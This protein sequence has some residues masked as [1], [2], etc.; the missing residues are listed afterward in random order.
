MPILFTYAFKITKKVGTKHGIRLIISA[1]DTCKER[2]NFLGQRFQTYFIPSID[3]RNAMWYVLWW[4]IHT[5]ML[6]SLPFYVPVFLQQLINVHSIRFHVRLLFNP[7]IC[8]IPSR[9]RLSSFSRH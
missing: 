4:E 5:L 7:L 3:E 1:N 9:A 6:Q 8:F 2:S